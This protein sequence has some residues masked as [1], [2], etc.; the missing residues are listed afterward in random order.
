MSAEA[1]VEFINAYAMLS[2]LYDTPSRPLSAKTT[3]IIDKSARRVLMRALCIHRK[4][5][6]TIMYR[7][8]GIRLGMVE[9]RMAQRWTAISALATIF[10]GPDMLARTTTI[11]NLVMYQKRYPGFPF[12]KPAVV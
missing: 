4:Y 8:D 10:N 5:D 7:A 6:K 1:K 9:A 11:N 12:H 2:I 3:D